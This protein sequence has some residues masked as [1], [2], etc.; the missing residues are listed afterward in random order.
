MKLNEFF[1]AQNKSKSSGH[2]FLLGFYTIVSSIFAFA[3]S[4]FASEVSCIRLLQNDS[5]I[6]GPYSSLSEL[7]TLD[8]LGMSTITIRQGSDIIEWQTPEAY[9]IIKS[10][11]GINE[12]DSRVLPQPV[13]VWFERQTRLL[14]KNEQ[15]RSLSKAI[16]GGEVI[17]DLKKNHSEDTWIIVVREV[18]LVKIYQK[19]RQAF[20]LTPREAEVLFW[21]SKG[22]EN[23]DIGIIIG[24]STRTV[25]KHIENILEK[26]NALNRMGAAVLAKKAVPEL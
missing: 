1:F 19:L 7:R 22:K 13:A 20:N 18:S 23:P 14:E 6:A 26:M 4:C 12:S 15:S 9:R 2:F 21:I 24:A 17:L 16:E 3:S 25:S 11:Y 8:S 5:V 10:A